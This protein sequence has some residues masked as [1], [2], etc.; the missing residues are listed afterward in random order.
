[1]VKSN[2]PFYIV[3]YLLNLPIGLNYIVMYKVFGRTFYGP[4]LSEN[5]K[6]FCLMALIYF[7]RQCF[8]QNV[9]MS[10]WQHVCVAVI[11]C[12]VSPCG[13]EVAVLKF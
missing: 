11:I 6:S 4:F 3:E 13:S 5:K 2:S 8:V 7:N 9:F 12:F 10:I 1:M